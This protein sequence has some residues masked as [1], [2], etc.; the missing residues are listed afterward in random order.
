MRLRADGWFRAFE[1]HE[2]MLTEGAI[3]ERLHRDPS[4]VLDPALLHGALLYGDAGRAALSGL[5][6]EYL[7]V[8]CESALPIMLQTPTWRVTAERLARS[9]HPPLA[10]IMRDSVL[11]LEE[12]RMACGSHASK[13]AIAGLTGC[14]G[15]AYKPAEALSAAD[16]ELFHRP[17]IEALSEAD[18]DLLFAATMPALSE[19]VGM[20]RLMAVSELPYIISFVLRPSGELLDGTPLGEAVSA[21]DN[22]AARA[23]LGYFANC[24]HPANML[25]ALDFAVQVAPHLPGRIVGLQ[26]NASRQSPEE[27]NE[28]DALKSDGPESF[29]EAIPALAGR[30]GLRIFGGCCGTDG[31]YLAALSRQ[32]AAL[33]AV[34]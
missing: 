9:A 17:Q 19:A 21:I 1:N 30:H 8:A 31:R 24:V 13:V 12:L 16:A 15:D 2:W 20:A 27:L 26:G 3:I 11:L 28:S 32:I 23:P 25:S 18:P 10:K 6:R 34:Q 7:A 33:K 22:A 4:I 14:R 29:V 5:W